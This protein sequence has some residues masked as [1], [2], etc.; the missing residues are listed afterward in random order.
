MSKPGFALIAFG[1]AP[2]RI[3]MVKNVMEQG[4]TLEPDMLEILRISSYVGGLPLEALYQ[5]DPRSARAVASGLYDLALRV[6]D[7]GLLIQ[8]EHTIPVWRAQWRDSFVEL[9]AMFERC[10]AGI[11]AGCRG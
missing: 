3:W 8:D 5:E 6:R 11:D 1:D 9:A 4:G 7:G 10:M 2:D